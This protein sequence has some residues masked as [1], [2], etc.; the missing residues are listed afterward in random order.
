MS[1]L[2][3]FEGYLWLLTVLIGIVVSIMIKIWNDKWNDSESKK[4]HVMIIYCDYTSHSY[5]AKTYQKYSNHM[6]STMS[7]DG[8]YF[9]WRMQSVAIA[10]SRK[11]IQI[12]FDET[13]NE[14]NSKSLN[15]KNQ[16][17]IKCD[18]KIS[19]CPDIIII[20]DMIDLNVFSNIINQFNN[21]IKY[22]YFMHENQLT[23]PWKANDRDIDNKSDWI[24]AYQ[25]FKCMLGA[26]KIW[27]NSEYHMNDY[28]NNLPKL[29]KNKSNDDWT[30][31][32]MINFA[33]IKSN[34]MYLPMDFDKIN[35]INN[36]LKQEI[37]NKKANISEVIILWNARWESD[38]NPSLFLYALRHIKKIKSLPSFK[39]VIVGENF[40]Y[41]KKSKH[42]QQSQSIF[43]IIHNEFKDDLLQ[44]GYVNSYQEYI[45]WLNLSDVLIITSDHEFFGISLMETIYC[46][47]MVILPD[48][49]VY[50]EHF[51][52]TNY[53]YF[54]NHTSKGDLVKKLI[55][56]LQTIQ[57]DQTSQVSKI[58]D[59]CKKIASQYD[60][61]SV[62]NIYDKEI[63]SILI[64]QP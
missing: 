20:D 1:L 53:S 2:V 45:L 56:V 41:S 57:N 4:I 58:K 19:K 38:K 6:V 18:I 28:F 7:V 8:S 9:K 32:K 16:I 24:Y 33:K 29:I 55:N 43:D 27:W 26:N 12:F 36:T 64:A 34:I 52:Q 40:S 59:V 31:I 54:Y 62:C 35:I 61:H 22:I 39:L 21:D 5:W 37:R 63:N 17:N 46:D 30:A 10:F 25:N 50:T 51:K 23:I 14:N 13:F 42:S 47:T 48:N 11:F 44:F 60:A 15:L 49:L 3:P